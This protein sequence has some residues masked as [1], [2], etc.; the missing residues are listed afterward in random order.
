MADSPA[1][2]LSREQRLAKRNDLF[3]LVEKEQEAQRAKVR[4]NTARLRLLRL[5]REAEQARQ[6]LADRQA[7]RPRKRAPAGP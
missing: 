3:A 6:E 4:E 2:K 1:N 7:K 5:A